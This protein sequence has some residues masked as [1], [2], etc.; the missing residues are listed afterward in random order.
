M[1]FLREVRTSIDR[2][3]RQNLMSAMCPYKYVHGLFRNILGK[4][5]WQGHTFEEL[6][7]ILVKTED[8]VWF[9]VEYELLTGVNFKKILILAFY[10][11]QWN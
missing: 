7:S 10:P 4:D 3:D 2:G 1:I 9:R 11:F 6:R 5:S 8:P